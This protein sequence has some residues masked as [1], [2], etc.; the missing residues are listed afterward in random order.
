M[1]VFTWV[2]GR[3]PVWAHSQK[4]TFSCSCAWFG[5]HDNYPL[6]YFQWNK[7]HKA[8]LKLALAFWFTVYNPMLPNNAAFVW[9]LQ[10]VWSWPWFYSEVLSCCSIHATECNLLLIYNSQNPAATWDCWN[11]KVMSM[12]NNKVRK[13]CFW[14][15]PQPYSNHFIRS[16]EQKLRRKW[17]R[18]YQN[19]WFPHQEVKQ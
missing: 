4:Q 2:F 16:S 18:F 14:T 11:L 7:P 10:N 15:N 6:K 8:G 12:A 9:P 13:D 5:V 1:C 3:G 17:I 19:R